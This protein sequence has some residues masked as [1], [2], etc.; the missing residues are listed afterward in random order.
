MR[1]ASRTKRETRDRRAKLNIWD[2][3]ELGRGGE[4]A[5]KGL[6]SGQEGAGDANVKEVS[7]AVHE[8]WGIPVQI[9]ASVF[10]D[11]APGQ[12]RHIEIIGS[13]QFGNEWSTIQDRR[14][15]AGSLGRLEVTNVSRVVALGGSI[16]RILYSW[17]LQEVQP[18][19][20]L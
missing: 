8:Q 7:S 18:L 20:T 14:T 10:W 19:T 2:V 11:L 17:R 16:C 4:E 1:H 5:G 12:S 9:S 6:W 3:D 13:L 15:E